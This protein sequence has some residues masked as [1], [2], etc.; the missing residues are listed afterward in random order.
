MCSFIAGSLIVGP[1]LAGV[2]VDAS[3][4]RGY[5]AAHP[6]TM[7][8][9][10]ILTM[11]R[12]RFPH[13]PPGGA[14]AAADPADVADLRRRAALLE[15]T[16]DIA[17]QTT[18]RRDLGEV[19]AAIVRRTR[20]LTGADMAYIALNTQ[21][22]TFIRYSDGVRTEAYR[23]IRMP[24]GSGVLGKAATGRATVLTSDYLLDGTIS[25]L[26]D[27]D[28]IVREEGVRAILGVP[29]TLHGVVH[30]ALLV[31]DRS[32][33]RYTAE[34]V[35]TVS[36]LARHTSA[37]LAGARRL[38]EV[39]AALARLHE[40][41]DADLE[42]ILDLQEVLEIDARLLESITA[43]AE[44]SAYAQA[45]SELIGLPLSVLDAQGAVL[46]RVGADGRGAS[47]TT[48]LPDH[49]LER[50]IRR[51]RATGMPVAEDGRTVACALGGEEHLG[52]LVIHDALPAPLLPRLQRVTVFLGILLLL[53]RVRTDDQH[54][55]ER[56]LLDVVIGGG[57]VPAELRPALAILDVPGTGVRV[58]AVEAH[59]GPA[60]AT[61]AAA[62][63]I[64]G[65]A[66]AALR[67]ATE[68][69]RAVV[70]P[71]GAHACALVQDAAA[72]TV[73]QEVLA[74]AA[75]RDVDVTIGIS[76]V[77]TDLAAVP[78]AHRDADRA[79]A[80]LAALGLRGRAAHGEDL[81]AVGLLLEALR[82]DPHAPSPLD[83]LAPLVDHDA[84]RSGEL[85]RTAWVF[86]ESGQNVGRTAEQLFLHPNTVR[87]RLER[88]GRVLGPDWRDPARF[89]DLHLALR[90]WAIGGGA[91]PAPRRP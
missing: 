29:M 28:E 50:T 2:A 80:S 66:L 53:L 61:S 74:Q 42:R 12:W 79:L 8:A 52:T 57:P 25:H 19:L 44:V 62:P 40:D 73:A 3:W 35:D 54:R 38:E 15:V 9:D 24:L 47:A 69:H 71:H 86:A 49:R 46:A 56:A 83:A 76:G 7:C 91:G 51:A 10:T 18:A 39:T 81:G 32:P 17:S 26:H 5:A 77:C 1:F 85:T 20:E 87:Q 55:R 27:I 6:L 65:L 34:M 64:G 78:S 36:I 72:E 4:A 60:E 88:I 48:P 68:P 13:V 63:D 75:E 31:A 67:S 45:A 89:L 84:A 33:R 22:E 23:T 82:A 70:A 58:L 16:T 21:E 14:S 43:H 11:D 30:G 37:A 59:P 90:A 41:R